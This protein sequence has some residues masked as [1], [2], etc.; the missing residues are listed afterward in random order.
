[1]AFKQFKLKKDLSFWDMP[2]VG[3][4][5]FEKAIYDENFLSALWV[6][7]L[8]MVIA[9]TIEFLLGLA[10][11]LLLNRKNVYG[12]SFFMMLLMTPM[13]M[14]VIAGGLLWRMLF[15]VRWGAVN[16]VVQWFGLPAIDFLGTIR[17]ALPSVIVVDIW[18]WTPFVVLI[19]LAGLRAI[20]E[21]LYEAALVDGASRFQSFFKITWP[22]LA[23][24]IMIVLLIRS[25]DAF[26]IFD[27]VYGLTFGGP[28]N[29][30]TTASF[31]IYKQGFSQFN[32][33][34]AAA[35]SWIVFIV[36]YTISML[37]IRF[38][39]PAED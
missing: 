29:S 18:Q 31:Y 7:I 8:I 27:V 26:K 3:L 17:W 35:L 39:K 33:G 19:L 9:V 5:N 13:M 24:P 12:H 38:L 16:A 23:W 11:A 22:L 10:I 30:T 2:W 6:T 37:I 21:E 36:V 32:L 15:D 14:P 20:P 4:R 1:M 25:M 34:Y 28:G